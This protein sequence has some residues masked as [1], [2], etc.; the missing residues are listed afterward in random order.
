VT[1]ILIIS[2][3]MPFGREWVGGWIF[4]LTIALAVIASLYRMRGRLTSSEQRAGL[5]AERANLLAALS[6]LEQERERLQ[7][8]KNSITGSE[9][10]GS[11]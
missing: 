9:A 4:Y 2:L 6:E 3:F 1:V 11:E 7:Q 5:R 10:E 8:L